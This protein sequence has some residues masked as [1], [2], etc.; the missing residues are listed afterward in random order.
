MTFIPASSPFAGR[1][2]VALTLATS[3]SIVSASSRHSRP[4]I[5]GSSQKMRPIAHFVTHANALASTIDQRGA[6]PWRA[7][8]GRRGPKSCVNLVGGCLQG[9]CLLFNKRACQKEGVHGPNSQRRWRHRANLYSSKRRNF[10]IDDS[11][12]ILAPYARTPTYTRES[13][14]CE[15][16]ERESVCGR[17]WPGPCT[18]VRSASLKSRRVSDCRS[19]PA[20]VSSQPVQRPNPAQAHPCLSSSVLSQQPVWSGSPSKGT[21]AALTAPAPPQWASTTSPQQPLMRTRNRTGRQGW[22]TTIARRG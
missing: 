17:D 16:P 20:A 5:E 21:T 18:L 3:Q 1:S 13:H 2:P 11:P 22:W 4:S 19:E 12:P 7:S 10:T 8:P 14:R 15:E 9:A 6:A